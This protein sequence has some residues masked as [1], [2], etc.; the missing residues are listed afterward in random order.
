MMARVPIRNEPTMSWLNLILTLTG[1][2][3]QPSH[4]QFGP[5]EFAS[6]SR[7]EARRLNGQWIKCRIVITSS[8][9]E[10]EGV[11]LYECGDNR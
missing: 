10:H 5:I 8:E 1:S 3:N 9:W 11:L 6:L 4:Q 2:G 7:D